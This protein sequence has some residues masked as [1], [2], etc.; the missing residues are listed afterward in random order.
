[1]VNQVW[2]EEYN[3]YLRNLA[4]RKKDADIASEMTAKFGRVFTINAIRLQRRALGIRKKGGR[5][6]F[7][8]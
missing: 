5:G 8:C 4:G 3:V 2:G 6:K 7:D 1:M